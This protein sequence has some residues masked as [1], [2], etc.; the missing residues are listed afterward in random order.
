MSQMSV[1]LH[2]K[3]VDDGLPVFAEQYMEAFEPLMDHK[4][5]EAERVAKALDAAKGEQKQR[6]TL[7]S[8]L[9]KYLAWGEGMEKR[10]DSYY[11]LHFMTGSS[12]SEFA[13]DMVFMLASRQSVESVKAMVWS[14]DAYFDEETGSE[15]AME[16]VLDKKAMWRKVDA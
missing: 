4:L 5:S 9:W 10:S 16:F 14:Q 2:V 8:S 11:L 12:G 1:T 3:F 13:Q 7:V 15:Y 6:L